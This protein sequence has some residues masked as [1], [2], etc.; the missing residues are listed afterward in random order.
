MNPAAHAFCATF[1]VQAPIANA[2]MANIAGGTLA[3]AVTSAGGLGL[4]GGGYGDVSWIEQQFAIADHPDVGVGLITWAVQDQPDLVKC[5]AAIGV[6]TFFLSFGDPTVLLE[7]IHE[8]GG[9]S[10]CQVQTFAEAKHA[11]SS[12]A[13]AIV[14]QGNE[15]GGHGRDNESAD[16]LAARILA[17]VPST[18]LLIAGG[19]T[20]GAD[21]VQAWQQGAAGIVV[22]TAMYATTEALDTDAVKQHLAT[23]TRND[24]VRTTVFDLVRGPEWPPGYNGRA[25]TNETTRRWHSNEDA[26]RAHLDEQRAEYRHATAT[27]DLSRRVIWA[28]TGVDAVNAVMPAADLTR[29]IINDAESAR[30]HAPHPGSTSGPGQPKATATHGSPKTT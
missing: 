25:L 8:V 30:D 9:R 27:Q 1:R 4:I 2:P 19:K 18:P 20:S 23:A 13:D 11:A 16:D 12:G 22:G 7:Q 24:I 15:A 29:R 26:L 5:L 10:I 17:E 3:G 6:R 14:A 21:L 28:G